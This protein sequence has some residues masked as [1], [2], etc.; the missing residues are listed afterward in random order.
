MNFTPQR[1]LLYCIAVALLGALVA[2]DQRDY[3]TWNCSATD[4]ASPQKMT[5]VLDRSAMK[6]D[7][8]QSIESNVQ[9][10]LQ[11]QISYCGSLGHESYFDKRCPPEIQSSAVRFTPNS[12]AL[13]LSKTSYQCV[14]L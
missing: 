1:T 14:A 4:P 8:A 11:T 13:L 2:C 12:G 3:V 7:P 5:I 6:F 9:A 10:G